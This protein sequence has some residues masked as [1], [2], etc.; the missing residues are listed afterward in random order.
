MRPDSDC[1]IVR[2][3]N[4][5][6]LSVEQGTLWIWGLSPPVSQAADPR[7]GSSQRKEALIKSAPENTR[8]RL[9]SLERSI[10]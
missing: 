9:R 1:E 6:A 4:V 7:L 8:N 2:Y 3:N 10:I 5:R